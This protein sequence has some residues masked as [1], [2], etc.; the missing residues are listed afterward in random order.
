MKVIKNILKK[1]TVA[2]MLVALVAYFSV[3]AQGFATPSNFMNLLRQVAV[4]GIVSAGMTPVIITGQIDLSVGSV[5]SFVS[6][7]VALAITSWDMPPLAACLLGVVVATAAVVLNGVVVLATGMP[8][9]LCTLATMQIYQGLAYLITN[10][11]PIYGLPESM[12]VIGQGYVWVVPVPV[13]IVGLALAGV[14][15]LLSRTYL[16]RHIY[17]VGSN[18]EATRL[19]GISVE[20]TTLIAFA[21]CGALTGLAACVQTSRLFGGFPTAGSG[22][23]MEVV[24]AVVVGGISFSGGRGK[25]SGVVLGVILMGV[26]V[27]GLGIMGVNTY[28]QLVFKGVV[29]LVVVGMDC[30]QRYRARGAL[31]SV[32]G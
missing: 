9:M 14:A 10:G 3:S 5:V 27:N 22:L 20:K 13:I 26:L 23:E 12:R 6:C 7:L 30:W 25:P 31:A 19:S 18:A 1:Y 24:T 21:I 15:L 28:I 8:A 11:T 17:A 32:D 29:L 2:I 16:G 4:L